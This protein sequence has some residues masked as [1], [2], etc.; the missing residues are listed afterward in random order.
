MNQDLNCK[1]Q[2]L[3]ESRRKLGVKRFNIHKY[4]QRSIE[5]KKRKVI[6][7]NCVKNSN[8]FLNKAFLQQMIRLVKWS[9]KLLIE[10]RFVRNW[11]SGLT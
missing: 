1:V 7:E 8:N 9:K 5:N 2:K 11:N 6:L 3:F 4:I 10:K